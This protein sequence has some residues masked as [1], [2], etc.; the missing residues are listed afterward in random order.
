MRRIIII[1]GS[2]RHL[3]HQPHSVGFQHRSELGELKVGVL[4]GELDQ[5]AVGVGGGPTT[6]STTTTMTAS[7]G[8]GDGAREVSGIIVSDRMGFIVGERHLS[9]N[10]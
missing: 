2:V 1:R 6:K 4:V 9:S 5:N 10:R 7:G 3:L 8:C